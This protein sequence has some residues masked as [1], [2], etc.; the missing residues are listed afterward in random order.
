MTFMQRMVI[1]A[2]CIAF[3]AMM[4]WVLVDAVH[5]SHFAIRE[6]PAASLHRRSHPQ[7][8]LPPG[9]QSLTGRVVHLADGDTLT[10]LASGQ[11]YRIR[12]WGIDAPESQ[13]AFGQRAK[14]DLGDKVFGRTVSVEIKDR[15]RYGRLVGVV[16]LDRRNINLEMVRDGMA[17]WYRHFAPTAIDFEQA[18]HEARE[19]QRGLWADPDPQPPWYFRMQERHVRR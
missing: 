3:V 14:Q 17:W 9:Q 15:D 2:M 7:P 16:I 18:E 11:Q 13:Q 1:A 6:R 12:L 5:P 10:V 8:Q 19:A 4:G